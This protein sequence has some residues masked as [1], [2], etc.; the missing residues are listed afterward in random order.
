MPPSFGRVTLRSIFANVHCFPLRWSSTVRL[1]PL[2]PISVSSRPSNAPTSRLSIQASNAAKSGMPVRPAEG[3]GKGGADGT[4]MKAFDLPAV[5][6]ARSGV[7]VADAVTNGRLLLPAKTVS[8]LSASIR[9]AIS[10]PTKLR[11]SARIAAGKEAPARDAN[12]CF[13]CAGDDSA[14][15]IAH[16]DV[17]N[18]QRR[19][20]IRIAFKL[21]PANFDFVA[22]AEVFLDCCPEPG[23]GDVQLKRTARQ[24]PPQSDHR[25]ENKRARRAD[26]NRESSHPWRTRQDLPTQA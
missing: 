17:A 8:L 15:P 21:G 26:G 22:F 11:R 14:I 12:F 4:A 24:A 3:V 7:A 23:S 13:W 20:P 19:P 9:T 5:E 18:A 6:P 16:D 2:S 10:A 1:P 25:K